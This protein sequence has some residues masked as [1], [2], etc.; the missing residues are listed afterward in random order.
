MPR[1]KGGVPWCVCCGKVAL[2]STAAGNF[3]QR[4]WAVARN[5]TGPG[6]VEAVRAARGVTWRPTTEPRRSRRWLTDQIHALLEQPMD[7]AAVSTALGV[8]HRSVQ[9][10]L[11]RMSECRHPRIFRVSHGVYARPPT[12]PLPS[13]DHALVLRRCAERLLGRR[14][15]A[16]DVLDVSR[17]TAL[18]VINHL[19]GAGH[20]ERAG[21]G[22][23]CRYATTESGNA[24]VSAWDATERSDLTLTAPGKARDFNASSPLPSLHQT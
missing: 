16:E 10:S 7:A 11:A 2:R 14:E 18:T 24:A 12:R 15:I 20:L 5:L 22:C 23:K 6:V 4:C 13:E 8:P 19:V 1:S 21:R 17:D 3:C 9:L